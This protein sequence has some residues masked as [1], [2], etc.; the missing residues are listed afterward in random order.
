L[1]TSDVK[2]ERYLRPAMANLKS[3]S[4]RTL[5]P[6]LEKLTYLN[7]AAVAP[8]PSVSVEAVN[9]Q[10]QDVSLF[11][12]S[13][14]TAWVDTK[15]RCR[16]L[17][18][19]MLDVRAGQIAFLRNTSDGFSAVAHGLEWKEGDNIVSFSGEFPS[20]FYPWRAIRDRY[21]VELRLCGKSD[22]IVDEE[23]LIRLIDSKTRLVTISAVQFS[24]GFRA[25]LERIGEAARK[26]GA[27][28]A[29]D[30]IQAFGAIKLNLNTLNVD[31]AAGASH[32]WLCA[33]EGCGILFLSERARSLINPALVGWISVEDEWNFTDREQA[34]INDARAYESGTGPSALFYGLEQSL[35]LL[36]DAGLDEIEKHVIGL[37]D[38]FCSSLEGKPFSVVGERTASNKSQIVS[39]CHTGG[40]SASEIFRE[41]EKKN[42]IVSARG[43]HLRVAPHF[44]NNLNDIERLVD[45]LS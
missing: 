10:L 19:Q 25:D 44:F 29:V 15:Q 26:A 7:S 2:E 40:R 37:A 20:N 3:E 17:V 43:R 41:L 13:H 18:A 27:L 42:I 14:Y 32:K 9:R 21:G 24:S 23:E 31:I 45:A 6:A 5:F 35:R 28:F 30:I 16:E 22:G 12:S 38:Y 39:V 8:L 4:F 1:P 36:N 11:G 34:F 33:P